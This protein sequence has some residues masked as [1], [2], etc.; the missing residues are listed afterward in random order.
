MDQNEEKTLEQ[1]IQI[2]QERISNTLVYKALISSCG[3]DVIV[4]NILSIWVIC[5][6][7]SFPFVCRTTY[8]SIE[9]III[10]T[11]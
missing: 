8:I 9:K 5:N 1:D 4:V 7:L 6:I 3:R 2:Y 11:E 10:I